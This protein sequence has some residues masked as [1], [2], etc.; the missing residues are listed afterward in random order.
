MQREEDMAYAHGLITWTDI[1]LPDPP[2]GSSFYR[3]LF[4]WDAEDQFAPDGSY[5]YTMFSKGGKSVAGLGPQPPDMA[6]SGV[7]PMWNTYVNVNDVD[8]TI[9]AWTAGGGSVVVPAMDVM[10]SGRMA[11]VADPEGA[12]LA[13]WQA[14]DHVGGEVFNEHGALTWNELNTRD[15]AAAREF[16]SAALGWEF[17]KFGGENYPTD[18][19]LIRVPDKEQG[20]PLSEDDYNGGIMTMDENW[21]ADLPAHWMIYFHVDDTDAAVAKL[22]ELGGNVSVPTF[23]SSA[24]RMAVVGDPQGG[25]FSL[26]SPPQP[27]DV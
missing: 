9:G 16:Y 6:E 27:A 15:S 17:E 8:N 25:T 2:A 4:G 23:D 3:E 5:I 26:I 22:E 7:P 10:T 18:Y 11:F 14:G 21:P 20:A 24:G 12:V 19:W 13:L 1:S